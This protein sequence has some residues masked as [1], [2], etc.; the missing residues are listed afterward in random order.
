MTNKIKLVALDL[1]GTLLNS[2]KEISRE[3]IEAIDA[4]RNKG[5]DVVLTT[6]RP[7]IAIQPFL[8]RLNMLDFDDY[9]VTFNGGLVQRNTGQIL[10]KKS[11]SYEEVE[12]IKFLTSR[13]DIP[14]D[15][16]SEEKVFVTKS[17]RVSEYETLNKLL[18]FIKMD[19]NDVPREVVYNKIVSCTEREFL[20]ES[21]KRIPD[22][23]F[24]RFEIF[25][26]QAKLLE[27]MPKG[28]N[29][30]Y[31]LTQ[32][33]GQLDLQ[34]ENVMAMGDE[35]NDLS[36]IAWAGFGVAMGNAVDS[37]K[38]QANIISSLTND[39]NA[40]ADMIEKYVL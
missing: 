6:G 14:C 5:V 38:E 15:I 16:L 34:P 39:Q 25:K 23:F 26:T 11:F 3:N 24:S 8:K 22:E 37:V 17:P 9:S 20:D 4:A 40:V 29:K 2:S 32:L 10:S 28:I 13:L 18:T 31:G 35:A 19:F 7:L 33:I 12:E 21:L 1:D 36:M 27:F 30:A